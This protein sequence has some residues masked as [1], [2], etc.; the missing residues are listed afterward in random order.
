VPTASALP[1]RLVFDPELAVRYQRFT[2]LLTDVS[3]AVSEDEKNIILREDWVTYNEETKEKETGTE[4]KVSGANIEY[5][6]RLINSVSA[7]VSGKSY[8][9]I[10]MHRVN[11]GAVYSFFN[12]NSYT[13]EQITIPPMGQFIIADDEDFP[14]LN[15]Y[16]GEVLADSANFLYIYGGSLG[17]IPVM[18][19]IGY[20]GIAIV[21]TTDS[22]LNIPQGSVLTYNKVLLLG[23]P[24]NPPQGDLQLSGSSV[25]SSVAG[26]V[27]SVKVGG[28]KGS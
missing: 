8:S 26:F 27:E 17:V 22:D 2:K 12:G 1:L 18:I 3:T 4:I 28:V 25:I 13:D 15:M 16:Q 9:G 24:L 6:E 11:S 20:D 7:P 14:E 10:T 5:V 21:N 19:V 23:S